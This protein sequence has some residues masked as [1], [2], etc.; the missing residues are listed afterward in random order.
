ML[1][2]GG[3][4]RGG[5]GLKT[6]RI[7]ARLESKT[8]TILVL[9]ARRRCLRQGQA[10]IARLQAST[11]NARLQAINARLQASNARLS[12]SESC[13]SGVRVVFEWCPSFDDKV[14]V[15]CWCTSGTTCVGCYLWFFYETLGRRLC[16]YLGPTKRAPADGVEF[17][18]PCQCPTSPQS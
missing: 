14:L 9:C 8:S 5:A 16:L 11:S 12:L 6:S 7:V 15:Q 13:P 1:G 4:E 2:G 3:G 10:S 17:P 18:N